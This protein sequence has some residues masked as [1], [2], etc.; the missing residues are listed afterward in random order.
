MSHTF[1][2]SFEDSVHACADESG[3]LSR[4]DAVRLLARH[5][6]TLEDV[7]EDA[8][9]VCPVALDERK[10]EALLAWLGY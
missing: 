3:N 4:P 1:V 8:A 10:A 9:G 5:G 6:F 7:Y 2:L